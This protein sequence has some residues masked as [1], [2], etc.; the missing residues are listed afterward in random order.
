MSFI[1]N[2]LLFLI[3]L[4]SVQIWAQDSLAYFNYTERQVFEIGGV[5]VVGAESRDKNAIRSL[6]GLTVGKKI[7]IPGQD[8]PYAVKALLK[9]KLFEDVKIVQQKIAGEIIFL[10]ILLVERSTLSRYSYKGVKKSHH[11]DLNDIVTSIVTKGSI[12]TDDQKSLCS[13]KI[14]DHYAQKGYPHAEVSVQELKDKDKEQAI[15]LVFNIDVKER[16]KVDGIYFFGNYNISDRKLRKAMGNT[17]RTGTLFKKSKF[18]DEDYEQDKLDVIV[19]YNKEGYR[20]AKILRDTI[21]YNALGNVMAKVYL[22]EGNRYYFR[23]IKW[24]GNA[25]YSSDQL[26]RILGI[27]KGDVYSPD[28]LEN[29]LR[30]SQD[31]RDIS[32]LYLDDG[33]L[34]FDVQPTEVAVENDSIDLEMR[35]FEGAQAT[36]ANVT[37]KGND[38][39]HEHVVRREIRTRPG[40]KFSRS[41]IIRSQREIMNLGYFNPEAME[42]NTPVNPQRGTVDIEYILEERPSD[43]LEL[44]AGYG[45]TSGLLGTLGVTFNNFSVANMRDLSSWSPL[46]QG[47]GQ[48]VSVRLQSNSRFFRS[49]NLSFTEPWLGGKKRQSLTIGALHSSFDYSE[50]A[51]GSL[52][53]NR[54]FAG[55]GSQLKWPDDF[56]SFSVTANLEFINLNNYRQGLFFVDGVNINSGNFKNFNIKGIISRSSVADPTFPRRGSRISVTGQITPPYSYFRDSGFEK[57]TESEI[58]ELRQECLFELGPRQQLTEEI[59][60]A[61]VEQ[62]E[63]SRKHTYLEYIKIRVDGDW[64]FNTFNKFVIAANAKIGIL[65]SWNDD[66]GYSPFERFEL[67]GDGLSNQ[68]AGITGKDIIALRGY[69]TTDLPENRVGGAVIFNKYTLELRYPLSLNPSSSIYLHS[70]LQAGNS[71]GDFNQFNPFELK[72]SAGF[73][74][75][76]FLPMFGLLGFDYGFGLDKNLPIGTSIGQYGKFSVV[77]GFEP[78]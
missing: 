11:D 64:Y 36:I 7:E 43:Q 17:K 9:L 39:T 21:Y 63:L 48:K 29:R 8:I 22:D 51:G 15:R 34:F 38:R 19:K 27:S 42:M 78:D 68:T 2:S 14:K 32:S 33:Y 61:K 46:P 44:S 24:K 12:V 70:F 72:R 31:G 18:V 53:I 54:V 37:I 41:D 75:R 3:L 45:G 71:W 1:K 25:K 65:S 26:S 50:F 6:T 74:L 13:K 23:D 4:T 60:A 57:L 28:L 76:A 59:L 66:I 40:E 73:G 47:D 55:I 30:F 5:D 49:A 67:G 58:D 10:E 16:V 52:S 77:L 69:E 35:I 56:F 20:D 62:E